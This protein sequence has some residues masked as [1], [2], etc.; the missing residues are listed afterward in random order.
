MKVLDLSYLFILLLCEGN[1]IL[2]NYLLL[3]SL[4]SRSPYVL[5]LVITYVLYM[6]QIPILPMAPI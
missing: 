6:L 1:V 4:F 5:V 2:L 3:L